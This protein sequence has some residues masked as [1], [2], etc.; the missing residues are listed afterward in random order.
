M[1]VTPLIDPLNLWS[2]WVPFLLL[3]LILAAAIFFIRTSTR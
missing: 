3:G 1:D 2:L